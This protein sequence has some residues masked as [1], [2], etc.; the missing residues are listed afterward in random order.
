MTPPDYDEF[1]VIAGRVSRETFQDVVAFE[2]LFRK[3]ARRIN[4]VAPSTL[5]DIWRRHI[6][7]SAQLNQIE[8]DAKRW[9]DLGSGGGFPGAIVALL[10]KDR[11]GAS[12][13]LV[14][15]NRKKAAF[16]RMALA[17]LGAPAQVHALRIEKAAE[18]V[19]Q[20]EVVTAR[21]LAPLPILLDL[22][23][24]WLLRGARGL[25]HKGR[26]YQVEIEE[27]AAAWDFDLI[28]HKSL[29]DP[30]SVILDL[31]HVRRR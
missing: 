18:A 23:E 3:W 24:P 30:A 20:P 5:N 4:L 11:P 29:I 10:L 28:E 14:E 17:D 16:L 13:D 26:D 25:F 8:P 12:I 31:R 1:C 27:S 15:S 19:G 2:E 7:D 6:L 22:A 21:A 9:L